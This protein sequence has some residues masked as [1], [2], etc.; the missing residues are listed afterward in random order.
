MFY[1]SSVCGSFIMLHCGM[2]LLIFM[3]CTV[4]MTGA[5]T[6]W[7]LHK[8]AICS[9]EQILEATP[10]KIAALRPLTS[11]PTNHPS[12][13]SKTCWTSQ[14]QHSPMD[15]YIWTHQCWLICKNLHTS[16]LCRHWMLSWGLTKRVKGIHAVSIP[17]WLWW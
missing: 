9:F 7:E 5:R 12:K 16:D 4:E 10:Y 13:I 2:H 3:D 11:Y 8:N 15:S 1:V 14:D 6:R 17:W